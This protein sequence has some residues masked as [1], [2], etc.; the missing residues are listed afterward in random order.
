MFN[1]SKL[2]MVWNQRT[3][4]GTPKI[5]SYYSESS[6]GVNWTERTKML[7]LT[8][9]QGALASPSLHLLSDGTWAMWVVDTVASPR[10]IDRWTA[11]ALTGPWTKT[12]CTVESDPDDP[13][14]LDVQ[15]YRGKWIMLLNT[16]VPSGTGLQGAGTYQLALLESADGLTWTT[17]ADFPEAYTSRGQ[18]AG[19]TNFGCYKSA[20]V[21]DP[22]MGEG[23]VGKIW[24]GAEAFTDMRVADITTP[25][26]LSP[27]YIPDAVQA[28]I[29]NASGYVVGDTFDRANNASLGTA[30]KGGAWSF[31]GASSAISSNKV[32]RAAGGAS[33]NYIAFGAT[34]G[35]VGSRFSLP[36]AGSVALILRCDFARNLNRLILAYNAAIWSIQLYNGAA[37]VYLARWRSPKFGDGTRDPLDVVARFDDRNVIAYFNG[38]PVANVTMTESDFNSLDGN[39]KVGL[40]MND[41]VSTADLFFAHQI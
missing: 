20:L 40:F 5:A 18:V 29:G 12:T 28:A 33:T 24:A 39:L 10:V 14:H 11:T 25:T 9:A 32:A 6:D 4:S 1:G 35:V 27:S 19:S 38:R 41:T 7:E 16:E 30:D 36:W 22:S 21:L 17:S 3:V 2:L 8:D 15:R 37:W 34:K 13:W 31:Y 26:Q 23:I